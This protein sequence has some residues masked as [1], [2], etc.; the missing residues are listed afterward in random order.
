MDCPICGEKNTKEF[1]RYSAERI[2]NC[3]V[4]KRFKERYNQLLEHLGTFYPNGVCTRRQCSSCSF[5]YAS[6]FKAGDSIFYKLA[7]EDRDFYPQEKWEYDFALSFLEK[8]NR[9]DLKVL[10]IGAGNGAFVRKILTRFAKKED[11]FATDFSLGAISK[12]KELGI[13]AYNED[14]RNLFPTSLKDIKFN[15][16][17]LFQSLEHMDGVVDFVKSLSSHLA[18]N[19]RMI[20]TVP[21]DKHI[22]FNESNHALM[23]LPPNH[24]SR[25]NVQSFI[26]LC[27]QTELELE[28]SEISNES[29]LSKT[30]LYLLYC[31]LKKAEEFGSF[32]H[33][34][35]QY[36]KVFRFIFKRLY[37]AFLGLIHI[38]SVFKLLNPELGETLF[39]VLKKS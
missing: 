14:I 4:N 2:T 18:S 27:K 10:E 13:N 32:P 38:K 23:D 39:V 20:I 19:G 25:W 11:I 37:I 6:P 31:Y 35:E 28:I 26:A 29:F 7:Y 3:Y 15:L 5:L 16:I 1:D 17:C 34:I 33:Q 21:N 8:Q 30:K 24:V 22:D 36:K 9:T 12:L